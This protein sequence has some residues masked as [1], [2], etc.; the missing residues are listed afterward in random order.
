[1]VTVPPKRLVASAVDPD[2]GTA[3]A[4]APASRRT[5]VAVV[6]AARSRTTR[7]CQDRYAAAAP[8]TSVSV[9]TAA[10]AVRCPSRLARVIA[11]PPDT[12][13][14]A[15]RPRTSQAVAVPSASMPR[16]RICTQVPGGVSAFHE[17]ISSVQANPGVTTGESQVAVS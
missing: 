11:A 15:H 16:T 1:M 6:P 14:A 7:S 17:A 12:S 4:T 3:V 8:V 9:L 5:G 10:P 2:A 13:A